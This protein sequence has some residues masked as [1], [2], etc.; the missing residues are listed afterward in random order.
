[1]LKHSL[2]AVLFLAVP[3]LAADNGSQMKNPFRVNYAG[4]LPHASKIG[5]FISQDKGPIEWSLKGSKCKGTED[6]YIANDYASGDSFY[7]ID[8][9]HCTEPGKNL[10]L[11]VGRA[12][13]AKFEISDD[14]YRK[15]KYEFFDYF[16][17][18][19]T[20]ATFDQTI[21]N[22]HKGFSATF[23]YVKDAGDNGVYPVNTAE[24]A[25]SLI[26]LLETYPTVNNYYSTHLKNGV[27]VYEQLKVLTEQFDHVFDHGG[28]L[29]IAKFHTNVN[30]TWATCPP[31]TS[32]NCVAKPETKAT[33]STA[34][35]LAA[36]ARLH[37]KYGSR[38]EAVST[39]Q[40]AV[41]VLA[42]A[43]TEPVVCL[44]DE[45]FG[46]EGGMY[47]NNDVYAIYRNPEAPRDPCHEHRD[48]IED[49]EYAALA[50]TYLAAL[51]LGNSADAKAYAK[52]V[53]AHPRF[54]EASSFWWGAVAMEGNLSLLTHSHLHD[55]PLDGLKQALINKAEAIAANQAKGYPGVTWEA[56]SE[57]W[58][59]DD[60]DHV[61]A[62][63]R[64]GSHRM[65][66]ND[67]RI[68]MAAAEVAKASRQPEK[69]AFFARQAIQVL[70][71]VSGINPINLA[72]YTAKGYRFI[73]NAV[74]RTHDGADPK[75]RW[76][77]KLVLGP[78]NWTNANDPDM[79]E[80][81]SKP[82]LKMF[83]VK[84]RGWASR[85]ISIDGNAAIVPVVYFATEIAPAI[86]AQ[87]AASE[88]E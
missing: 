78:N 80:F 27:S 1:M 84:G 40:R 6:T 36:M 49:D 2:I 4:Y 22:W 44:T 16:R 56:P 57:R 46:G 50:E 66:L 21:D 60:Q 41:E 86:L 48:N 35:T 42:N 71:H 25:W 5:I 64:W 8:F 87:T 68:L 18:H 58:H 30:D 54:G 88:A 59:A 67:A 70:D 15:L 39:Y 85:E 77:G 38:Q 20:S 62:N 45:A 65:A 75:D 37:A 47:P 82:G 14:P 13:S 83:A 29:A 33:F 28:K 74:K 76:P 72:M 55:L 63:V 19:Q 34:R 3:A 53:T 79:P 9:S 61:D 7:R 12:V 52:Q 32:G 81:G 26:N 23:N 10:R 73:E 69:A 24:A 31:H 17:D 43:R 51:L 11:K